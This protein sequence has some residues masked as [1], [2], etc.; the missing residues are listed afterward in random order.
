MLDIGIRLARKEL[1]GKAE[2]EGCFKHGVIVNERCNKLVAERGI[3]MLLDLIAGRPV[4]GEAK[5][6]SYA[7]GKPSPAIKNLGKAR[8]A[9]VIDGGLVP[10]GIQI[11]LSECRRRSKSR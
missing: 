6:A 3:E 7:K 4:Q 9:L 1:V 10:W 8:I 2:E 11:R 5:L